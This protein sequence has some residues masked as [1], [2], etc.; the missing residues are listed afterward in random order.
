MRVWQP[1]SHLTHHRDAVTVEDWSWQRTARRISTLARLAAPYKWRTILALASLFAATATALAP[2]YL[3][4]LAI[5]DGIRKEDLQ[6]L[7]IVVALFLVA[8]VASLATSALRGTNPARTS[9][10]WSLVA[11]STIPGEVA[12]AAAAFRMTPS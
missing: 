10:T 2:P 6:A 7:T 12:G 9:G 8:G 5:D 1:G 4:K 3:A 11:T